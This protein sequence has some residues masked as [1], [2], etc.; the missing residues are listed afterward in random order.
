[1]LSF[2]HNRSLLS[3]KIHFLIV[4]TYIFRLQYKKEKTRVRR[5]QAVDKVGRNAQNVIKKKDSV[6][7]HIYVFN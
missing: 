6:L 5:S 3:T 1:M 4:Q 7:I 2:Y